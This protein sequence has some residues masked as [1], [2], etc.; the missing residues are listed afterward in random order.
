MQYYIRLLINMTINQNLL[1]NVLVELRSGDL[2]YLIRIIKDVAPQAVFK[3]NLKDN[4]DLFVLKITATTPQRS[5]H[6][7]NIFSFVLSNFRYRYFRKSD[8][9]FESIKSFN[10]FHGYM[11]T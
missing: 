11:D 2:N 9:P 3:T 4:L 5:C 1:Y 8:K 6:I 7:T 10:L